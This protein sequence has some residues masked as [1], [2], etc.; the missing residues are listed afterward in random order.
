MC[1]WP[2]T[3]CDTVWRLSGSSLRRTG[4]AVPG[5]FG[6]EAFWLSLETRH[7]MRFIYEGNGNPGWPG[8]LPE[9]KQLALLFAR[10]WTPR[11]LY[12]SIPWDGALAVL[13][14]RRMSVEPVKIECGAA[15]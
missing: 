1:C 9:L 3:V 13:A 4:G 8:Q 2:A 6:N 10:L 14:E 12:M 5:S 7:L 11:S 15:A